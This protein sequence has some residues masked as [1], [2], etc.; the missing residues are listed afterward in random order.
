M[1]KKSNTKNN[2]FI[3]LNSYKDNNKSIFY[4]REK[5]VE[6][7]LS[8]IQSSSFLAITGDVASGKSS[9]INAGLIP[10]IKN[11]FNGINGNQWSIVN[12]RPGI[13][14]IEN[15]CHALSSD[16]NL[17][18]S[19]KSKTTDYNDYLTTIREKNSIGLVEIYRNCEIFSK[20]NFLIV[21][22]QLED[23]YNFPDLFDYNES[24]DEDLLFDLVSKTLKFKDLGI[25]FII[26]IDTGNYKKLS[27][28]DDLSKILSSSQFIL[29]PLNYNDLKEIIKKT[30]NAKNIQF[31][32]E[33]MDQFSVLVNETDNSLNPNFQ[34][35]F[36]KLYDIC[37]SDLNQQNGYVNSEKI[38]QIGDVD[39]II[40]VELENFYSS[41]DEKGKLILEKFFRSFI[42]FD[43]KNIGYYYQEYS[44]IK[45]Y[46]DV[47]DEY[48]SSLINKLKN[49]IEGILDIFNRNATN[50]KSKTNLNYDND[51]IF[52]FNYV[53]NYN[54]DRLNEW[55]EDE[56]KNYLN[57][58]ENSYKA[59][60]YPDKMPHLTNPLLKSASNW[61]DKKLVD[62]RWSK[63]YDFNFN[64]TVIYIRESIDKHNYKINYDKNLQ[65]KREKYIR[66]RNYAIALSFSVSI[67]FFAQDYYVKHHTLDRLQQQQ[68]QIANLKE[69]ERDLKQREL[70][71]QYKQREDSIEIENQR[72]EIEKR[73]SL[74]ESK[75]NTIIEQEKQVI[76]YREKAD[77]TK[78]E[79]E[80]FFQQIG[81]KS[82]IIEK[83]EDVILLIKDYSE[84]NKKIN[85]LLFNVDHTVSSDKKTI[86][87]F[88]IQFIETFKR[89]N[90]IL[91]EID[92]IKNEVG[93]YNI[94]ERDKILDVEADD[95]NLRQLTLNLIAKLNGK[96]N[97]SDVK[98]VDYIHINNKPLNSLAISNEGRIATGGDSEILYRSKSVF[99]LNITPENIVYDQMKF[100]SS[101]SNIEFID[102]DIL[103]VVLKN[104]ELWYANIVT[105]DKVKLYPNE[106]RKVKILKSIV[107]EVRFNKKNKF[108]LIYVKDQNLGKLYSL[109]DNKLFS[110]DLAN[111]KIENIEFEEFSNNEVINTIGYNKSNN[112]IFFITSNLRL[113]KIDTNKN[114]LYNIEIDQIISDSLS[115]VEKI[116][117]FENNILFGTSDG[118]IYS[119]EESENKLLYKSRLNVHKSSVVNVLSVNN[120]S[121]LYSSG[122]DGTLTITRNRILGINENQIEVQLGKNNYITDM[123]YSGKMGNNTIMTCDLN[124]NLIFW[125]FDLK[126]ALQHIETLAQN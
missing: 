43:K 76:S 57:F 55:I 28:Y 70:L 79:N 32:S 61:I 52:K 110:V 84:I 80:K 71:A 122:S 107:D 96:E 34:L 99:D 64:K 86:N 82:R 47:D 22:D 101:I 93:E 60:L 74:L 2:P 38:D 121:S 23:L 26:S 11:G 90:I 17:Y 10:R 8:I 106:K 114:L 37:L 5:Q 59:S 1:A 72:K 35:F 81:Q 9:F 42:N 68:Q 113:F 88:A 111:K 6:D 62:E 109:I 27:S 97:Y 116:N 4:S 78:L 100:N 29:H 73:I 91:K 102:E 83:N 19:D 75:E 95:K 45:N 21:I 67:A 108:E 115:R 30:F 14:P 77:L 49:K 66:K 39:E 51:D 18:I 98:E 92:S 65:I 31:D 40:S 89:R 56:K 36:K 7:A 87:S 85:S 50:I 69:L 33:V 120:L 53:S 41:L 13:S 125:Q 63:K 94:V 20:K 123:V 104:G 15:L 117:F 44:Y 118:W 103:A 48:L 105:K 58:S 112:N 16:G 124:G 12:F 3:S 126:T 54:W 119:Y 25:Y 24:D 46:T